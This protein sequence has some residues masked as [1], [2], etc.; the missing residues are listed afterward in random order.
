M[1]QLLTFI[2]LLSACTYSFASDIQT[3]GNI[4]INER[5]TQNLYLIG[6]DIYINKAV[7]GDLLAAGGSIYLRDSLLDDVLLAA[8]SLHLEAYCGDD[9]RMIAGEV[10]IS[11]DIM[12]DLVVTAG[13][14]MIAE[15]VT[16]HGSVIALAGQIEIYGT[17]LGDIRASGG[18]IE[19]HGDV[20]GRMDLRAGNI[21][22]D[23]RIVGLSTLVAKSI[24]L[25]SNANF[26]N[27]VAY[28]T[29]DQDID[30]SDHLSTGVVARYDNDLKNELLDINWEKSLKEGLIYWSGFRLI[31]GLVLTML[32]FVLLRNYFSRNA[33]TTAKATASILL[34]GFGALICLPLISVFAFAT[35]IGIPVGI[36]S[37]AIFV[38]ILMS[39]NALASVMGAFELKHYLQKDWS[40]GRTLLAS[41]GLF[42]GLR[43]LSFLPFVGSVVSVA[44][45]ALA[46]GYI[47]KTIR[48]P[49]N[50]TPTNEGN[51]L[52]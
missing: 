6:G 46:I 25:G 12:G 20:Q 9:L 47:I 18:E 11:E 36:I 16:I 23:G 10:T 40:Q 30:F 33:G 17:V 44:A 15:N 13:E 35:I 7:E 21:E 45:G 38:I 27:D 41:V 4:E 50:N 42:V 3:G 37:S 26:N 43:L 5:S 14:V 2:L 32:L 8:G 51:G 34:T 52:V 39:S 31:S 49:S 19:I 29:K 24:D 1:K 48:K 28:W 22:I